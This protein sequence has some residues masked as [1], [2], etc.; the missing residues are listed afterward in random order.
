L[1][2]SAQESIAVYSQPR[3]QLEQTE[4]EQDLHCLKQG[5]T[6]DCMYL[7]LGKDT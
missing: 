3:A 4:S 5:A 6:E 1:A 2:Y 7:T